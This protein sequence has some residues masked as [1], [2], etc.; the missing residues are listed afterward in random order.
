MIRFVHCAWDLAAC[1]APNGVFTYALSQFFP[2]VTLWAV[3]GQRPLSLWTQGPQAWSREV[4]H[5][6]SPA[7]SLFLMEIFSSTSL[8]FFFFSNAAYTE[9]QM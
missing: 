5:P 2:T 6:Q 4:I 9:L 3:R 7:K 8:F 1:L